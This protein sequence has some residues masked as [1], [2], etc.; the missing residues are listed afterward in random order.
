MRYKHVHINQSGWSKGIWVY[1][2][3]IAL[4]VG[5]KVDMG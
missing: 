4:L 3:E 2:F 1:D 5:Y